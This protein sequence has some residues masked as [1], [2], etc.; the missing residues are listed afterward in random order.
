M[1]LVLVAVMSL[2]PLLRWRRDDFAKLGGRIAIPALLCAVTFLLLVLLAPGIGWLPLFG[3]AIAVG[4]GLASLAPLWGRKLRRTPLYTWGMVVSHL[5]IAV[6][7]A[8]MA[9]ESAFKKETLVAASPGQGMRVGPFAVRFDGVDPVAGPNW[10]AVQANLTAWRG[11][12][13]ARYRMRPQQRFFPSA[14][15]SPTTE[16]AILTRWDG[17]LYV[18]VGDADENGRRQIRLWWKPFVTLI[19]LGGAMVALG[20]LLA[21]IGR[22]RRE[23][24]AR[25]VEALA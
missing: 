18:N 13:G 22:L 16:A 14:P 10:T 20:G 1:A 9:A 15:D 25:P 7:L 12:N 6:A 23:R 19:W 17:Q 4:A 5:G 3:L 8:G 24:R 11:E 21:L 2:G